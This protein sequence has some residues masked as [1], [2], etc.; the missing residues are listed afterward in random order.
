MTGSTAKALDLLVK[1]ISVREINLVVNLFD[2]YRVF[3]KQASDLTLAEHF[4]NDRLTN[5]ESVIFVVLEND[6]PIGFTQL[7]PTYSSV[8]TVRNWIL[9][10]L[11]VDGDYRKQGVGKILIDA[12]MDFGRSAG[13]NY[14]QLETAVDNYNAQHL[15][16]SI[17]FVKQLPGNEFIMYRKTV[18]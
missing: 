13:A 10:D 1:R 16:E 7:Y 4:L 12:A 8:R 3:Y 15:Y 11:Y 5:N 6:K 14:V 18:D 9:N 2:S 17:G